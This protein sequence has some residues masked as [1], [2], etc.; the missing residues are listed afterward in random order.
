MKNQ[1]EE[2]AN[3]KSKNLSFNTAE[4]EVG[5][6]YDEEYETLTLMFNSKFLEQLDGKNQKLFKFMLCRP[7][8]K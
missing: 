3:L 7:R 4:V 2:I 1:E 5:Y 8:K 6:K